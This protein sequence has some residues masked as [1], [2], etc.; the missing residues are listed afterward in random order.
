MSQTNKPTA[1]IIGSGPGGLVSA[2]LLA[3]YGVDVT[4]LEKEEKVGG[5]ANSS[6]KTVSHLTAGKH[7]ALF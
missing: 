1:L 7:F 3:H 6:T 5:E 2:L 4:I